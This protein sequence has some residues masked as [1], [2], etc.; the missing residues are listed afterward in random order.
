MLQ[1]L[2]P[3]L[4][5][6]ATASDVPE[7]VAVGEIV[8][9][10]HPKDHTWQ[11]ARI[12]G[13]AEDM[14]SLF[15]VDTGATGTQAKLH[16]RSL[17]LDRDCIFP[18]PALA[19]RPQLDGVKLLSDALVSPLKEAVVFVERVET[20]DKPTPSPSVRIFSKS[21]ECITDLLRTLVARRARRCVAAVVMS[22]SSHCRAHAKVR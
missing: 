2:Q 20:D 1:K 22:C 10:L 4:A 5:A 3:E 7:K 9:V 18:A 11:R 12:V 8:C 17:P 13:T 14:F 16:L 15:F 6:Y 19:L 21:G